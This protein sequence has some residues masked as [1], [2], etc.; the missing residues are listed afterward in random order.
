[1]RAV[2]GALPESPFRKAGA[3]PSLAA[4]PNA[5]SLLARPRLHISTS[6]SASDEPVFS[7]CTLMTD[8]E[9][10]A[11]MK[12]SF[13]EHGFTPDRAEFLQIDNRRGNS[14]D[15]YRGLGRLLDEARGRYVILCHQDLLLLEDGAAELEARLTALDRCDP[16]W[17]V[18]GNSGLTADMHHVLHISDPH[19]ENQVRGEL[20]QRVQSLD[21]NFLVVRRDSGIRPSEE[22]S[23]FHLYGTDLCLQARRAG[24]SAWVIDFH[25]RHLSPGR[26]DESFYRE[27]ANFERIWGARVGRTEIVATT[28]TRLILGN[29]LTARR[30]KLMRGIQRLPVIN[31]IVYR[32]YLAKQAA[33]A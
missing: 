20:P 16:D 6:V 14:L 31:G 24:R 4:T 25:L 7:V 8:M 22:L 2:S 17:A 10:Y 21:E 18:A 3:G 1:V 15:A 23:G 33:E 19:G 26:M 28:C 11:A 12:T 9:Q 5:P 27:Q 30:L 32:R 29:D 13:I